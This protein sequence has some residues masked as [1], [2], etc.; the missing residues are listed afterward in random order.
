MTDQPAQPYVPGPGFPPPYTQ[1]PQKPRRRGLMITLVA[2]AGVLVLCVIGSVIVGVTQ[3]SKPTKAAATATA[4]KDPWAT[5]VEATTA[6]TVEATTAAVVP[7]TASDMALTVKIKTKD[8]F[9]SAGC[10]VEYTI[11]AAIGKDVEPQECEVTYDVHGLVDTQTGTL[12]F[13]SDGTYEQDS[14]QSGETSSSKKKLTV[15]ITD[16]DC[17]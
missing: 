15:K 4:S 3:S 16:V 12:D 1:P 7:L 8:C 2:V 11:K 13:H 14:Y 6:P 10:N 9:G 5:D 17:S